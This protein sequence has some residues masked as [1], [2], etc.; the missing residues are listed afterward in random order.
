MNKRTSMLD[1]ESA[2]LFNSPGEI[3][4]KSRIITIINLEAQKITISKSI[5]QKEAEQII[6]S[7][8]KI[9]NKIDG[10]VAEIPVSTVGKII[11]HKGYDISRIINSLPT[12]FET[13]ILGW[14]E[15][16][17]YKK[18]HKYHPNIKKYHHYINKFT[19][20]IGEYFIRFTLYEERTRHG[21]TG[22]CLIHS[23]A[24]SNIAIYKK[25]MVNNVSVII[26]TGEVNSSSFND[27][28]LAELFNSVK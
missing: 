22:R 6:R 10:R 2:S 17:I 20:G 13:S 21:K 12:L 28:R 11:K 24:I 16:E 9:I 14:S 5:N 4:R 23:T 1:N 7:L 18:G 3:E 25:T 8:K 26:G 15:H 27:Y 19:D